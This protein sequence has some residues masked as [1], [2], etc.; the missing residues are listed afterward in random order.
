MI[1]A[2]IANM[3]ARRTLVPKL[4]H[5][6]R[7]FGL[8]DPRLDIRFHN[9]N[10]NRFTV[11]VEKT[12][13]QSF[14]LDL[15]KRKFTH[16]APFVIHRLAPTLKM[17]ARHEGPLPRFT[18]DVSDGNRV[19]DAAFGWSSANP[20]TTL[21]TDPIFLIYN[22]FSAEQMQAQSAPR[23]RE[24]NA[25]LRW[26]GGPNGW[27]EMRSDTAAAT[28][29]AVVQRIRL[30][31]AG[32]TIPD[33]DIRLISYP[34]APIEPGAPA[35][36]LV[37]S[38]LEETSWCNDRYAI[39]IDGWT[40]TWTNFLVRLHYGCCVLKVTS[41]FGY[42]QWYYDRIRAWEH[43]VPVRADL[44][45]LAEKVDW[46]RSHDREAQDI[47]MR[48]Q[49]FARSMTIDGESERAV[50]TIRQRLSLL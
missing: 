43:F 9:S 16:T 31:L 48:G 11:G 26:R 21:I 12:G 34:H 44:A 1:E 10:S 32:R 33:T 41:Q 39:D 2:A 23:W 20:R 4:R 3:R 29:P 6:M 30:V 42:R 24:R 47:A 49:A 35:F 37:G 18:L 46:V 7:F 14:R 28:D 13:P 17:L 36:E 22:G 50:E 27:G 38:N 5:D 19:S 15:V 8:A 45:D 25:I 40:N